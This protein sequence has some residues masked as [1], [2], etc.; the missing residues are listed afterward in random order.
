M[1]RKHGVE[2][3]Y[4]LSLLHKHF[5]LEEGERIT[6]IRGTSNPLTFE[7]VF[8]TVWG[9]SQ[10]GQTICPMEFSLEAINARLLANLDFK[11]FLQEFAATVKLYNL[12]DILGLC[13]YPGDGYPGRLKFIVGRSNVNLTPE[14]VRISRDFR[15]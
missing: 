14:E 8:P 13:S 1:F 12:E 7:D 10:D 6:D 9:L 15:L 2:N 4:G 11:S 5:D 3:D